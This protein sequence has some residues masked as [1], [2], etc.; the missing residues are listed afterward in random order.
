ML[1]FFFGDD[2]LKE[3]EAAYKAKLEAALKIKT[4][5]KSEKEKA[6]AE[7]LLLEAERIKQLMEEFK[8][9]SDPDDNECE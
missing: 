4:R 3:M 1:D 2:P 9:T 7:R 5:A 8:S 6:E